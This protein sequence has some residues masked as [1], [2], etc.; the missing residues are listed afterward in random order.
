MSIPQQDLQQLREFL[1][2]YNIL[3]E[4]CF[5]SCIRDYNSRNLTE[6]EDNCVSR[7]IDKQMRVNR[8][9]MLVFAE[10]APKILFKQGEPTPTDLASMSIVSEHGFRLDGRRPHQIRNISASLGTIRDA[11][12]SAYFEQGGTKV[13]CVVYGPY[14]GKRSKQLEDRCVINCIFSMTRFAGVE[15]RQRVRADRKSMEIER[16]IEKTFEGAVLTHLF[17]TSQIDIYCQILQSDGS[18]L[19]ACVNAASLA[20]SDAG[21]PMKGL[22]AAATCSI[23]DGQPVVDVNQREETDILPRLTLATLRGEDEVV[24]VELQ[25]RVHVD[26]LPALMAAAKDTCK[27]VHECI[28]AVIVD[29][30]H[31]GAYFH[32]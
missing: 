29:R 16:L 19:A 21:I 28:C 25:N 27:G 10:Q 8:R 11:E 2:V 26:H 1:S 20:M 17:P 6:A 30:L 31:R 18:H 9:L 23:V 15:R 4:K 24:L 5:G 12:G 14:E 22:V 32:R 13:L 3:T 7:C